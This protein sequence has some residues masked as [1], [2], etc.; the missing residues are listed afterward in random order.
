MLQVSKTR[1]SVGSP[2]VTG[3]KTGRGQRLLLAVENRLYNAETRPRYQPEITDE[4]NKL[5][6][7]EE[8]EKQ[9]FKIN[10]QK[11]NLKELEKLRWR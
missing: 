1:K 8:T 2:T 5:F 3:L 9:I 11:S 10:F 7:K 6:Q 4:K